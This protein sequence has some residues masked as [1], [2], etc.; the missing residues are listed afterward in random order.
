MD[1]CNISFFSKIIKSRNKGYLLFEGTNGSIS[2]FSKKINKNK[3]LRM[4]KADN[5]LSTLLEKNGTLTKKNKN[6]IINQMIA[7]KEE[8]IAYAIPHI[9]ILPTM[10]CNFKCAYCYV[11]PFLQNKT[12][13]YS[14][15]DKIIDF[16]KINN[17][18]YSIE[19]FGGEP[20]LEPELIEYFYK[21][22]EKNNFVCNKSFLFTNG[23]FLTP[24]MLNIISKYI[25]EIQ[26]TIDG[27]KEFHDIRRF[28]SK[29]ESSFDTIIR[30]LDTLYNFISTGKCKN[31]IKVYIRS[32]LDKMNY[33][34]YI[35]L[36][37]FIL[38]R[39]DSQFIVQSAKVQ[40][41]G[42][43]EYDKNIFSEKE[44]GRFILNLFYK[45]QIIFEPLLPK[46]NISVTNCGAS[47]PKY[48][49]IDSL[50]NI[51]KCM[52]DS[53]NEDRIIGNCK[54]RTIIDKNAVEQKYLLSSS[55]YLPNK[56]KKCFLLFYCWGGC[57]QT[58]IDNLQKA[59]CPYQKVLYKEFMNLQYEI[60]NIRE[61][62]KSFYINLL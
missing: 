35:D 33:T 47:Y 29:D 58:R 46:F 54:N 48:I 23:S 22:S 17:G 56:C 1:C 32:N 42:R 4:C 53:G 61:K 10:K 37:N 50:G 62:N 41:C 19:W 5:N 59:K 44:F 16:I 2:Y 40:K 55:V 12:M 43:F 30:N 45:N 57:T 51:Y 27:T 31:P 7:K 24:K 49:V 26:I 36:R 34:S 14:T 38:N 52:K 9:T 8:E 13:E 15:I 21:E 60:T 3:L 20:T 28:Y 11:K 6:T 39:Y 25:K 18:K